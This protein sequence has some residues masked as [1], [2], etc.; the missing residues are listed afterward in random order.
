MPPPPREENLYKSLWGACGEGAQPIWVS[1]AWGGRG[2]IRGTGGQGADA[3]R[4]GGGRPSEP[5]A[6]VR[7]TGRGG[8]LDGG[9]VRPPPT[10][11]GEV[12]SPG[13]PLPW[14]PGPARDTGRWAAAHEMGGDKATEDRAGGRPVSAAEP[15][16][17]KQKPAGER[18]QALHGAGSA[19]PTRLQNRRQ[20]F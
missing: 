2:V 6:T 4:V 16:A 12:R 19:P 8:L 14:C 13:A 1:G 11:G 9:R 17:E 20:A 7:P 3:P 10:S 18:G 15:S 5:T